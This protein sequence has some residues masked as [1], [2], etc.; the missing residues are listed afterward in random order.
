MVD[1]FAAFGWNTMEID[2]HD[3][4]SILSALDSARKQTHAPS[5]IIARTTKGKGVSRFENK[6]QWHGKAP[7]DD[8]LALA[9][10]ELGELDKEAS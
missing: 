8:D 6:V 3:V 2:G 1:K 7:G 5:V 9:L 4:G 10:M